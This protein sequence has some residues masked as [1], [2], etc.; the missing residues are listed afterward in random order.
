MK[1]VTIV[2]VLKAITP[3]GPRHEPLLTFPPRF[4]Y[5]CEKHR[6]EKFGYRNIYDVLAYL[7]FESRSSGKR[8]TVTK[9]T[10]TAAGLDAEDIANIQVAAAKWMSS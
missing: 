6:K 3:R 9:G 1:R 2:P 10:F 7:M 8:L 4:Y 5:T